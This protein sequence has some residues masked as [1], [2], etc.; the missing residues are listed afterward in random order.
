MRKTIL[1]LCVSSMFGCAHF[2]ALKQKPQ[3]SISYVYHEISEDDSEV[4]GEDMAKVLASQLPAAK[5][6]L[7]IEQSN[8]YLRAVLVDELAAKGFGILEMKPDQGPAIS[9]QYFVTP[10]DS[11]VLVRMRYQDKISSRYY[12]RGPDGALIPSSKIA[13]REAAQ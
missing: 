3:Q 12:G 4:V 8:T 1:A 5:T 6:T 2:E 9:L 11:G 7:Y 10:L 13:V